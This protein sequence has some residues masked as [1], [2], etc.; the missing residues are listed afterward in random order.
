V[1][2]VTIWSLQED[3]NL[4]PLAQAQIED[5]QNKVFILVLMWVK[6][7][8]YAGESAKWG[9]LSTTRRSTFKHVFRPCIIN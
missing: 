6:V 8:S 9:G 4:A 7:R 1:W 3:A 2:T 5:N